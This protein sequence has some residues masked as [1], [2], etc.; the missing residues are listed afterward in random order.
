ML[1]I[2]HGVQLGE[3]Y[4][5]DMSAGVMIDFI[6]DSIALDLRNTLQNHNF[7]S[8]LTDGSTDIFVAVFNPTPPNANEI[9]VEI[10]YL[11]LADLV[12]ANAKRIICAI[13][14]S[15]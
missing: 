4:T 12:T 8:L 15:F 3:A 13:D 6:G 7:F 5:N 14:F 10:I 11:D 1:E 9:K 2:K